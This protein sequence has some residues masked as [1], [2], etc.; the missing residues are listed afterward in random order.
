MLLEVVS[1]RIRGVG[2]KVTV[3]GVNDRG[4]I[5]VGETKKAN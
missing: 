2:N 4:R 1:V 3:N 5:E